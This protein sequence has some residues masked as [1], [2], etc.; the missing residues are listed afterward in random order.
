MTPSTSR[1]LGVAGE[2]GM[3]TP[4]SLTA[5]RFT[6]PGVAVAP[7]RDARFSDFRIVSGEN[8]GLASREEYDLDWVGLGVGAVEW[9]PNARGALYPKSIVVAVD[10][11]IAG[12]VLDAPFLTTGDDA[13]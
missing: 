4:R 2:C 11:S 5:N 8:S 12:G 9:G 7:I 6:V 1:R 3:S 13:I 10:G